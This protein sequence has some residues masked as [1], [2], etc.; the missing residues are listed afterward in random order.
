M[1]RRARASEFA[2]VTAIDA[3]VTGTKDLGEELR[4]IASSLLRSLGGLFIN[5]G[6]NGIGGALNLP[7]FA[8]GGVLPSNG[9]A[10]VGEAGPELAFSNGGRTT[11]VPMDA[12]ADARAA[13]GG[14]LSS[15]A[16]SADD[17][18]MFGGGA[19]MYSSSTAN[20]AFADNRSSIS[21]TRS[22]YQSSAEQTSYQEAVSAVMG[23]S[24]SMVIETQVINGIEYATVG[25]LQAATAA[26]TKAARAEVFAE[27][28][29][30]PGLRRKVGLK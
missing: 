12:F 19:S 2:L 10:I 11:I 1:A 6:L 29:S 8:S 18:A 24:G 16:G 9:P 13:M 3:A 5:A 30:N 25:E 27:M 7:T 22:V 20:S 15:A 23:S 21:N 14:G 28:K 26:A 17:T 4:N